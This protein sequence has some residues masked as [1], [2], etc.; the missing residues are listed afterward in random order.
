MGRPKEPPP[1]KLIMSLIFSNDAVLDRGLHELRQ[2]FGEVD[3]MSPRLP[4]NFTDYYEKEMGRDLFRHFITFGQ[5]IPMAS[6]P[7]IK[8][9]TNQ[10]EDKLA[11]PNGERRINIDPGYLCLGHLVLATTKAYTH[12]PYLRE[13]IYADLTLIFRGKSYQPL[14][15]TYPDYRQQEIISLFNQLRQRYGDTVRERD[16]D[17]C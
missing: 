2:A 13:G 4:F 12:R 7:D 5:L 6:L 9:R 11:A 1:S 17:P 8:N 3:F 14:E 16:A 10:L 15:W